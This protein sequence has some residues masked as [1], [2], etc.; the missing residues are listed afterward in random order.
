MGNPKFWLQV[1]KDYIFENF[2]HLIQY[3][4][5]YNYSSDGDNDD[6]D[7][8]LE[9]M[10]ELVDEIGMS[11]RK[12]PFFEDPD[13]LGYSEDSVIKLMLATILASMKAN[14]V[15]YRAISALC[16]LLTKLK[17]E[18][19]YGTLTRIYG[20]I[21]NSL[22]KSRLVS[23]GFSWNDI[24][25]DGFNIGILA[26]KVS[27]MTFV[28]S[29]SDSAR[30]LET[31]GLFLLPP[32]GAP[33]L[34]INNLEDYRKGQ[35]GYE[36]VI[37]L[38]KLISI[39]AESGYSTKPG[40]F[41]DLYRLSSRIISSMTLQKKTKV[42]NS[43]EKYGLDDEFV[44]RIT[45]IQYPVVIAETID[46]KHERISGKVH[47][48][49]P[50]LRPIF[51]NFYKQMAVG[52]CLM[53]MLSENGSFTFEIENSFEYS[54]RV[55]SSEY[56]GQIRNA[57][58]LMSYKNGDQWVTEDGV[59]IGIDNSKI[60]QLDEEKLKAYN[61][62]K[63]NKTPLAVRFYLSAP[64][65]DGDNFFMYAEP[66]VDDWRIAN[67]ED[68]DIREADGAMIRKYIED[69]EEE[70]A[71]FDEDDSMTYEPLDID[72]CSALI[73][74]LYRIIEGG[75]P[76]SRL[77]L[78]YQTVVAMLC[79]MCDRPK[80]FAFID[81]DRRFLDTQVQFVSNHS[82]SELT[83]SPL[84]DG[85]PEVD[86]KENLVKTLLRYKPSRNTKILDIAD[87]V[88]DEEEKSGKVGALVEASNN[89]VGIID[90]IE[91]NNIKQYIAR[92]LD[93]ED[94]YVSIIDDRTFYG[95]E[96]I[97]LEFK[98]SA[99]YPPA[100]RRRFSTLVADPGLQKWTIIK[101]V[102]G[103][104]NTRSGGDLLIG[105]RDTGYACGI[106]D[107]IRVLAE[108]RLIYSPNIDQY[109]N[110]LQRILDF[111]FKEYKSN[112]VSTDIARSC[113]EYVHEINAEGKTVMRIRV[114]PYQ[115][116]I[117]VLAA[118]DTER[119]YGICDGYVRLSGRTVPITKS[120]SE[121]ILKYKL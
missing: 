17:I 14:K 32:V 16:E 10:N 93:V 15:S 46:P 86:R 58:Y 64:D 109:R 65:M 9:C 80:E 21:V 54:Y 27:N 56:A 40:D 49:P 79:D 76:S 88:T 118:N 47:I 85:N 8:T 2:D 35:K 37:S 108:M 103:F 106:E 120:L 50:L 25:N 70:A 66:M 116:S 4:R 94:E 22:R 31:R 96:S 20:V 33:I 97:S 34:T 7:D 42:D 95:T 23:P 51:N 69:S 117:V 91:Q 1:R 98:A 104:L 68:F 41:N 43:V 101:A 100:N 89:L 62:A 11:V 29:Q 102:C 84:L 30:Y 12:S 78:E 74:V 113:I 121:Q 114:R 13:I 5:L 55:H 75:L 72:E 82:I 6:F 18:L 83:H 99:V 39:K 57:K 111:A 36:D 87:I 112:L 38:P 63:E 110:Y 3:L 107:D 92:A 119:P 44:V 77:K 60:V 53:V 52:D 105:V 19:D 45:Y 61:Y 81:H 90:N 26:I 115:K 48:N 67:A 71:S 73:P 24:C 28:V 59:R